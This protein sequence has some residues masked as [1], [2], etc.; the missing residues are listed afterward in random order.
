MFIGRHDFARRS[1]SR[2]KRVCSRGA[3]CGYSCITKGKRCSA[4]SLGRAA[5]LARKTLAEMRSAGLQD[6]SKYRT[7]VKDSRNID[8]RE[9]LARGQEARH[10]G[11]RRQK[12]LARERERLTKSLAPG[13]KKDTVAQE[14]LRRIKKHEGELPRLRETIARLPKTAKKGSLAET[15]IKGLER[16]RQTYIDSLKQRNNFFKLQDEYGLS[17]RQM[18]Q[19]DEQ[20]KEVQRVQGRK[21]SRLRKNTQKN[22]EKSSLFADR[23]RRSGNNESPANLSKQIASLRNEW[24][25]GTPGREKALKELAAI[26]RPLKKWSNQ[27]DI[28][29]SSNARDSAIAILGNSLARS[30]VQGRSPQTKTEKKIQQSQQELER[31]ER[32][33]S[34]LFKQ[35]RESKEGSIKK[36]DLQKKAVQS[37]KMAQQSRRRHDETRATLEAL[38][39]PQGRKGALM[40]SVTANDGIIPKRVRKWMDRKPAFDLPENMDGNAVAQLLVRGKGSIIS[41]VSGVR[42]KITR[43]NRPSKKFPSGSV[44][45]TLANKSDEGPEERRWKSRQYSIS[46]LSALLGSTSQAMKQQ[47][48]VLE[49]DPDTFSFSLWHSQAF[50]RQV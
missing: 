36:M 16:S 26:E 10:Q 8:R 24:K 29:K 14:L 45:L 7:L 22:I 32:F 30:S 34:S 13:T 5:S 49:G 47:N 38:D 9:I 3:S 23:L 43:V 15:R 41:S 46:S 11:Q 21:L 44:T 25:P 37:E 42:R 35:A 28:V 48:I 20:V 33:S 31:A 12:K 1:K 50:P 19:L 6:S 39:A 27:F 18:R 40:P 17:D 2:K 4:A